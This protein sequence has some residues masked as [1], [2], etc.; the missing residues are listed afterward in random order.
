V[1]ELSPPFSYLDPK[2]QSLTPFGS[3][4]QFDLSVF[5]SITHADLIDH[6]RRVGVVFYQRIPAETKL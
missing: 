4:Y 6:I 3:S 1:N 2:P 5:T